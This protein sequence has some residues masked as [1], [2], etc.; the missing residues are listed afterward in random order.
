MA[1]VEIKI[2]F[3]AQEIVMAIIEATA[4]LFASVGAS[5]VFL[6]ISMTMQSYS[7]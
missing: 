7:Q 4:Y 3:M 1:M 5:P 6:Q 2:M